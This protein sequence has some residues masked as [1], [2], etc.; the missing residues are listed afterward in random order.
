MTQP[1]NGTIEYDKDLDC[2]ELC[3]NGIWIYIHHDD[4]NFSNCLLV[5]LE[6]ERLEEE[7]E[8]IDG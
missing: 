4:L 2:Y 5:A 7:R 3:L 1:V 8:D 6:G